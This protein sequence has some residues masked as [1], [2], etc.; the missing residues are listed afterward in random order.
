MF[1]DVVFA[2]SMSN[3]SYSELSNAKNNLEHRQDKYMDRLFELN[4]DND[5]DG[6]CQKYLEERINKVKKEIKDIKRRM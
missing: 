1:T 2:K 3:V 5:K 6:G 4:D